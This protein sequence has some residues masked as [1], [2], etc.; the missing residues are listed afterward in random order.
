MTEPARVPKVWEKGGPSPNPKG[1]PPRA[2]ILTEIIREIALEDLARTKSLVLAW[3]QQ[4]ATEPAYAKLLLDRCD[5]LIARPQPEREVPGLTFTVQSLG[6]G[7][8]DPTIIGGDEGDDAGAELPT[9]G[10][11]PVPPT[12][13]NGHHGTNGHAKR[14]G[15][16]PAAPTLE[17]DVERLEDEHAPTIVEFED[18]DGDTDDE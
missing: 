7:L 16:A 6:G 9:D 8:V 14:N 18:G 10:P 11:G 5:G 1:Q 12:N 13:G 4:S 17:V 2:R 3:F 15:R